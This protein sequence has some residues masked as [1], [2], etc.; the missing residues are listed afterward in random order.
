MGHWSYIG[1]LMPESWNKLEIESRLHIWKYLSV[2]VSTAQALSAGASLQAPAS[3][4]FHMCELQITLRDLQSQYLDYVNLLIALGN[5]LSYLKAACW[6]SLWEQHFHRAGLGK[7]QLLLARVWLALG[8]PSHSSGV[9]KLWKWG[10]K[11]VLCYSCSTDWG[12]LGEGQQVE[13]LAEGRPSSWW[14]VLGFGCPP[15]GTNPKLVL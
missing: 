6:R 8:S 4:A 11:S 1:N 7:G 13:V 12:V 9:W 15:Q 14:P 5:V 2:Q 3:C 10:K